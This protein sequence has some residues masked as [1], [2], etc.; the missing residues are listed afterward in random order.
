[1]RRWRGSTWGGRRLL[2]SLPLCGDAVDICMPPPDGPYRWEAWAPLEATWRSAVDRCPA[3]LEHSPAAAPVGCAWPGASAGG[4]TL[5][6]H[7]IGPDDVGTARYAP[8]MVV[9][10]AWRR[11]LGQG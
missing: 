11:L 3:N 10:H 4:G 1:A 5:R 9:N 8:F 6:R 7:K 2:D